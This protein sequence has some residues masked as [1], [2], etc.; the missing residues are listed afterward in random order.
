MRELIRPTANLTGATFVSAATGFLFWW[1]AA[2]LYL[3]GEMGVA[4]SVLSALSLI[5]T[6]STLG[7]NVGTVRLYPKF[8]KKATGT[9]VLVITVV[10]FIMTG[11]YILVNPGSVLTDKMNI[12]ALLLIIS[13]LGAMYTASGIAMV[14]LRKTNVFFR[15][16]VIYST[17]VV[18]LPF[19]RGEGFGGIVVSFGIGVLT[20]VTYGM[21]KLKDALKPAFS[22][23]FLREALP[24]SLGNYLLSI[25]S[26]LPIYFM[27]SLV[28]KDL[29]REMAAYYYAG[30][31]IIS[32]TTVPINQLSIILL[33]EG[34]SNKIRRK[35]MAK[36]AEVLAAYWI[37][38]SAV[39][40]L[41]SDALLSLFG[42]EYTAAG[43]MIKLASLGIGPASFAALLTTELNIAM[44][45][46]GVAIA[47]AL[48]CL[49][50]FISAHPLLLHFG[51]QGAALSWIL[52]N[53]AAL[54]VLMLRNPK[55]F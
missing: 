35:D 43:D 34:S 51:L 25:S 4:S 16:S 5:F 42:K 15:Q 3:P 11:I 28:L 18:P 48:N 46:K 49:V 24:I 27:P 39:L 38:T 32:L 1:A 30:F 36:A 10:S 53:S 29:G 52:S 9:T 21:I 37:V 6:L 44:D 8:G 17:R 7:L 47:S 55:T 23:E 50:F 31:M 12:K 33:R 19:L 45:S 54:P 20:G 41:S 40:I 13:V 2:R 14:P 22:V 26:S